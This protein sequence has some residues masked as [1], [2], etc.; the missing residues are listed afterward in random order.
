MPRP[1]QI[2]HAPQDI[3]FTYQYA[4][5]MRVVNMAMHRESAIDAWMGTSN[6]EWDGDTLV[7][8]VNGFT[9][10]QWLDRAG[11]H[12]SYQ[13]QVEERFTPLDA[14]TI[15]YQATLT[16]P[17]T[18]TRPWSM[19]FH[20]HRVRDANAAVME[21]R[22]VEFTEEFLYGEFRKPGSQLPPGN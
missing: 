8:N 16:D 3:L 17:D 10:Q 13:L 18:Y 11:N 19:Q 21:F 12:H 22:C 6:G 15:H 1:F 20:L 7:I 5:A 4:G 14:N 9:G 2:F